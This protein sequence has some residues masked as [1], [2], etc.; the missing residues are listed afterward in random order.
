[1]KWPPPKVERSCSGTI[2]STVRYAGAGEIFSPLGTA[3]LLH[4]GGAKGLV[5]P[6]FHDYGRMQTAHKEELRRFKRGRKDHEDGAVPMNF[7]LSK[8]WMGLPFCASHPNVTEAQASWRCS[9]AS[10]RGKGGS[11]PVCLAFLCI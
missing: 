7:T 3:R 2:G 6:F 5:Q 11:S 8:R 10:R 1:M 9:K 4:R